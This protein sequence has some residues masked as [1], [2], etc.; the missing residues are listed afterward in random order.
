[1]L[2]NHEIVTEAL[3][4][5]TSFDKSVTRYRY[6]RTIRWEYWVDSME[7]GKR[8]SALVSK[9][10]LDKPRVDMLIHGFEL[11]G[12]D[13]ETSK[14]SLTRETKS[15]AL[16]HKVLGNP[17]P[18]LL[19][20]IVQTHDVKGIQTIDYGRTHRGRAEDTGAVALLRDRPE[21]VFPPG[22]PHVIVPAVLHHLDRAEINVQVRISIGPPKRKQDRSWISWKSRKEWWHSSALA[23]KEVSKR[24]IVNNL[25]YSRCSQENRRCSY[26]GVFHLEEKTSVCL[27]RDSSAECFSSFVSFFN[28]EEEKEQEQE[29]EDEEEEEEEDKEEEG[30]E[31]EE[32]GRG[33]ER[34]NKKIYG[35][36]EIPLPS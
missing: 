5:V 23:R 2:R 15:N 32:E 26:R 8:T 4:A 24:R 13:V 9:G 20:L 35:E 14:P 1:M 12:I 25:G 7:L 19:E 10:P 18:A 21:L 16:R 6:D 17:I 3:P 31:E 30:E 34:I 36:E 28:S 11:N 29:Q 22:V 33:V 27:V